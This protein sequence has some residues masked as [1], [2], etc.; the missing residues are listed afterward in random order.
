MAP[1]P[2]FNEEAVQKIALVA[3]D[4]HEQRA[5]MLAG[6]Q[7]FRVALMTLQSFFQTR[8]KDTLIQGVREV[9]GAAIKM[10]QAGKSLNIIQKS[11]EEATRRAAE[12]EAEAGGEPDL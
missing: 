10:Q 6:I 5:M 3:E 11:I 2:E 7:E 9:K 8:D 1:H 4:L 12:A